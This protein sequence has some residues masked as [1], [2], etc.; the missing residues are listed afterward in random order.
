LQKRDEEKRAIELF[1]QAIGLE[2]SVGRERLRTHTMH[3][4]ALALAMLDQTTEAY[5]IAQRTLERI[6]PTRVQHHLEVRALVAALDP[7]VARARKVIDELRAQSN[8]ISSDATDVLLMA[9]SLYVTLRDL[10]REAHGTFPETIRESL[11]W[12]L[13]PVAPQFGT[14]RV[15][16]PRWQRSLTLAAIMRRVYP[17][18]NPELLASIESELYRQPG[19]LLLSQYASRVQL[20]DG[21]WVNLGGTGVLARLLHVIAGNSVEHGHCSV[22]A[23]MAEGWPGETIQYDAAL[24][25][26]Y[27][28]ISRL[29]KLGLRDAIE[30]HE[31]GYRI[32]PGMNVVLAPAFGRP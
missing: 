24:N 29:R 32:Q 31:G 6:Q 26:I 5:D 8:T 25:R 20:P 30:A 2:Q 12:L 14:I 3:A 28:A 18:L 4:Y 23:C 10:P 17:M 7:D 11:R 1:Q 19:D 21:Q 15:K 16:R 9:E 27:Q 22:D 13:T